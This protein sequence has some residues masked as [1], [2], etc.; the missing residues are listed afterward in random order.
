VFD[1]KVENK[2]AEDQ[3]RDLVKNNFEKFKAGIRESK[4]LEIRFEEEKY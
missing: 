2:I 3:L 4:E 1:L